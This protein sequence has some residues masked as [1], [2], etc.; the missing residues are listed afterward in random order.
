MEHPVDCMRPGVSVCALF[1]RSPIAATHERHEINLAKRHCD[2]SA[3]LD[4]LDL[5]G[6]VQSHHSLVSRRRSG[7]AASLARVSEHYRCRLAF[8]DFAFTIRVE[9]DHSQMAAAE[10]EVGDADLTL[11]GW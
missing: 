11:K 10:N 9:P 5:H 7:S 8:N 1:A 3:G 2:Q 6:P 4:H